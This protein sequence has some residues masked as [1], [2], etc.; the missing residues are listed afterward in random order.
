[1]V[2]MSV[3]YQGEKHCKLV[4]EPSGSSIQTD[5]P[6][7]NQGKGEKFSPTDLLG[8]SLGGC[9]L[10]I[11]AIIAERDGVSL[12]GSH[13]EVEKE[14][15]QQPRRRIGSLRTKVYLP[16]KI[17][18]E[19]RKKL[20]TAAHQCPVRESLHPEIDTSITFIYSLT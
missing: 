9:L 4:H 19:Y 1:M 2:R 8:A 13:A 17:P 14:M 16:A 3:F 7:D 10:T 12:V 20:E 6:K 5:A 15:V 18:L 11:M